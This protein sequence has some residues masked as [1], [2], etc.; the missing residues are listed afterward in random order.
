MSLKD[1]FKKMV[2]E[3]NKKFTLPPI[4]NIFFP[5]FYKGGQPKDAQFMAISLEGGAVGVSFVLLPDEK[6]IEYTAMQS[7]DFVGKNPYKFAFEFSNNDP[8][9][10]MIGLAAINAIC[11]HVMI[12]TN[13]TVDDATD[14]LGLLTVS[15]GDRIGMVGLFLGLLKTI[16]KAN[17][18][19]VV[20]EKNK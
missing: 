12:E 18:E 14:S 13:F 15:E 19:L 4:S 7:S 2:T 16:K 8:L 20:I 17:A 11:Q 10:E 5:P 1:E 9:K 6:M 3:L